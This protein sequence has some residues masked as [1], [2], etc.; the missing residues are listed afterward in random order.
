VNDRFRRVDA[1]GQPAP[2]APRFAFP[3]RLLHVFAGNRGGIRESAP[4]CEP[5]W[6]A[7]TPGA[8][9]CV[10]QLHPPPRDRGPRLQLPHL[11]FLPLALPF[12]GILFLPDPPHHSRIGARHA[13][14]RRQHRHVVRWPAGSSSTLPRAGALGS[15]HYA[16]L[17]A[18]PVSSRCSPPGARWRRCRSRRGS[19]HAALT[20]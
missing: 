18:V 8:D 14:P 9:A 6:Q 11:L 7:P 1:A 12:G 10:V 4:E 3:A 2:N 15:D 16:P 19:T 13:D 17:A 5:V 20:R